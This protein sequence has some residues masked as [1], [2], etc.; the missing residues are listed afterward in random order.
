MCSA[1]VDAAR[2]IRAAAIQSA[3]LRPPDILTVSLL[4]ARLLL[5]PFGLF[6]ACHSNSLPEGAGFTYVDAPMTAV[7]GDCELLE[8][9]GGFP[10][11][12]H[13]AAM[14]WTL[15]SA[16]PLDPSRLYRI[17]AVNSW[18]REDTS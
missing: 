18:T 3:N 7:N 10:V 15:Y 2:P 6:V 5:F 8:H 16:I 9:N 14:Y 17:I 12:P 13:C 1:H 4:S 11:P